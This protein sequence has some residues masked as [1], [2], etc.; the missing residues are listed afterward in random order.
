LL[1]YNGDGA[2]QFGPGRAMSFWINVYLG[3]FLVGLVSIAGMLLLGGLHHGTAHVDGH[4]PA[5]GHGHVQGD[6]AYGLWSS[7]APFANFASLLALVMC[8]GGFGY[9]ALRLGLGEGLSLVAA[10]AG[11]VGGAWLVVASIRALTR[12]EA[13]RVF[14]SDPRGTVA[15]VIAPIGPERM[16]EIVFSRDDGARQALPAKLDEQG[17]EIERD[18]Q[19]VVMRIERGTAYVQRLDPIDRKESATW[20][21]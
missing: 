1:D 18:A 4:G 5:A 17:Q 8:A 3:A 12:A 11:G 14:A 20:T 19:V 13:G 15:R 10:A 2:T 16:G 7:I 9:L 21:R 6:A